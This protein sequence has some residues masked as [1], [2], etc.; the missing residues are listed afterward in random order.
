MKRTKAL[1]PANYLESLP[2]DKQYKL[3]KI[4]TDIEARIIVSNGTFMKL[5]GY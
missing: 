2:I 4:K 5:G 3:E 1:V